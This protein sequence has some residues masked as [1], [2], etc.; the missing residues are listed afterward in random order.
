M[1]ARSFLSILLLLLIAA[2]LPSCKSPTAPA[3]ILSNPTLSIIAP[4]S[5]RVFDTVTFR[6]HY[7][8]SVKPTWKFNWQFGD[9]TKAST[10]DTT[11]SHVYDSAGTYNVQVSLVDTNGTII[12]KQ[13]GL[14]RIMPLNVPTLTLTVP[15]TVTMGDSARMS[16][17]CSQPLKPT[18]AFTWTFGDSTSLTSARDTVMHYYLAPQTYT[19]KVELNDTAK[20]IFLGSQTASIQV[21][22]PTLSLTVPNSVFWG[23]SAILIVHSSLP[24][25]PT[26]AY[27]W[28]LGDSTTLTSA[29]DTI[30]HYFVNP[31]TLTVRV[32]LNDTAHHVLLGSQTGTV[33]VAA[34]HF[35]LALLQSMKYVDVTWSANLIEQGGECPTGG[36]AY[37]K[38]NPLHWNGSEFS[39]DSSYSYYDTSNL[40]YSLGHGSYSLQGKI[41]NANT[42]VDSL[43]NLINGYGDYGELNVRDLGNCTA[44]S[45]LFCTCV[46]FREETDS[47]I[48]FEVFGDMTK[49]F[50]YTS[51]AS[52][53]YFGSGP[54]SGHASADWTKG[55]RSVIV[56][57]HK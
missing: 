48:V 42:L 27:S 46:P 29:Q 15:A 54:S 51:S 26:W 28:S 16:I 49:N 2:A 36:S 30:L 18:W 52:G 33:Q 38:G 22:A 3:G 10:T 43:S 37:S 39:I 50:S 24:L 6:A 19:L 41:D 32:S 45:A 35:N 12:A 31:G 53:N 1:Q 55:N 21:I 5:A 13:S 40:D 57:F 14:M 47:E 8:D 25:K 17:L 9:S 4:D 11:I 23:D 20:H 7:S 56:R 34:R 44:S